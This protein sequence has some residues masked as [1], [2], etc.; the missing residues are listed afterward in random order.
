MLQPLITNQREAR[1][2]QEAGKALNSVL[3]ITRRSC[4]SASLANCFITKCSLPILMGGSYLRPNTCCIAQRHPSPQ[5][6]FHN[7]R[8]K[9][10]KPLGPR[11]YLASLKR[12]LYQDV[13]FW[14]LVLCRHASNYSSDYCVGWMCQ[15]GLILS[16]DTVQI[17]VS[18][19]KC[20]SGEKRCFEVFAC[21][22]TVQNYFRIGGQVLWDL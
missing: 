16:S 1:K 20:I 4:S 12:P 13:A 18:W 11:D 8:L 2:Q 21:P 6:S 3:R 5:A 17:A 10:S 15:E 14:N 19:Q 9:N 22:I 7:T